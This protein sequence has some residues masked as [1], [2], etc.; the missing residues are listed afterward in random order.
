VS[1]S[2][3]LSRALSLSTISLSLTHTNTHTLSQVTVQLDK[4]RFLMRNKIEDLH[5]LETNLRC[6][7]CPN[8]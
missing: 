6:V 3:A 8:P 2:L 5:D 4:E 1:Q 7:I